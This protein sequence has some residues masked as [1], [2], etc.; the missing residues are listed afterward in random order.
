M[1]FRNTKFNVAQNNTFEVAIFKGNVGDLQE[2]II[3]IAQWVK[4]L[5]RSSLVNLGAKE[6]QRRYNP[7]KVSFLYT[8]MT[9]DVGCSLDNLP[10]AMDER[11]G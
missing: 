7:V 9:K 3:V 8:L 6:S 5:I 1:K 10:R 4:V 11:D 2:F